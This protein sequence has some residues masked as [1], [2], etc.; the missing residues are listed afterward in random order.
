M[1]KIPPSHEST[2]EPD[3][4]TSEKPP[5]RKSQEE[6]V[7][8]QAGPSMDVSEYKEH[9]GK[10]PEPAREQEGERPTH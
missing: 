4:L 2:P 6:F 3:S 7:D 1:N 9:G 10:I 5:I 8:D